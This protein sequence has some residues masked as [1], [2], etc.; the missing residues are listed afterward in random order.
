MH[1]HPY[2]ARHH[3]DLGLIYI[4]TRMWYT[5]SLEVDAIQPVG[6]NCRHITTRTAKQQKTDLPVGQ[7]I[8]EFCDTSR[9]FDWR[10]S[11]QRNVP[12]K[13]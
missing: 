10:I 12:Q 7:Y 1:P 11:G 8:R 3:K 5:K 6:Q 9:A 4:Q 2:R 13:S